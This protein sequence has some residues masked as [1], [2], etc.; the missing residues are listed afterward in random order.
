MQIGNM[1]SNSTTIPIAPSGR[2]CTPTNPAILPNMLSQLLAKAGPLA[3]GG[4]GL[5]R[6]IATTTVPGPLGPLLGTTTKSD[7]GS[8]RFA[9]Y[10]G[11]ASVVLDSAAA[12]VLGY[13]SCS[14]ITFSGTTADPLAQLQPKYLD[15]G[16]SLVVNGPIGTEN[17]ARTGTNGTILY[18]QKF[19]SNAT[20]LTAGQYTI[21]GSGGNDVGMFGV[22]LT[23]P[24]SLDWT[25]QT[26][27]AS[28]SRSEG[29]TV[30]WDPATGDPSG[31]VLIAGTSTAGTSSSTAVGAAFTCS[32]PTTAGT[33]TVPPNVLLALPATV[34]VSGFTVPGTLALYGNSAPVAFHAD[35]IDLGV[36]TDTVAISSSVSY[37]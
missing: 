5:T 31:Y 24:A 36:A 27:I 8:A 14:V 37:Q 4:I 17:I 12:E 3:I 23:V 11:P 19:D 1:V 10:N 7:S 21:T 16:T 30:K 33:F 26:Q 35:G 15:A 34:S 29:V 13:G 20:Y 2:T 32:A 18:N 9:A 28:V 6:T 22:N 25:N